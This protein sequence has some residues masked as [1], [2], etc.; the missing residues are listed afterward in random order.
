MQ[1]IV[2]QCD[3]SVHLVTLVKEMDQKF[4][5]LLVSVI[6]IHTQTHHYPLIQSH[7]CKQLLHVRSKNITLSG[8]HKEQ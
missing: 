5:V 6:A 3:Q 8:K 7:F 4:F 2:Q 1:L